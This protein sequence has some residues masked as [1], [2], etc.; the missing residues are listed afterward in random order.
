MRAGVERIEM[1][2]GKKELAEM[3]MLMHEERWRLM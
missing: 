3:G 1:Y 2:V